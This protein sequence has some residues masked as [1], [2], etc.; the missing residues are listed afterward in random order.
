MKKIIIFILLLNTNY[1]FSQNLAINDYS[2]SNHQVICSA[3]NSDG[4]YLTTGGFDKKIVVWNTSNYSIVKEISGLDDIPLDII[5]SNDD[6][7]IISAGKDNKIT[8]WDFQTG[9]KIST[10]EGHSDDVT[11]ISICQNNNYIVSGSKDK[12]II[13]W[14]LKTYGR[15]YTLT[16]HTAEVNSVCFSNKGDK[17]IS[18]SADR[19]VKI[20]DTKKGHLLKSINAHDGWVRKV[21]Y[22]P[23]DKHFASCGNDGVINIW[24][25]DNNSLY[26]RISS[27]KK[28]VQ[29]ISYSPDGN[30]I[31]SGGHDNF[32][33]L[34]KI[35]NN[36]TIFK[37]KKNSNYVLTTNFNPNGKELFYG[38]L[39]SPKFKIL[40]IGSLN[41][42]KYQNID[43]TPPLITITSPN[44]SRGFKPVLQN[45]QLTII[46]VA[47]DPSGISKVLI[48]GETANIDTQGNFSKTVLLQIGDNSF[49]VSATD[50]N[51]NTQTETFVIEYSQDVVTNNQNN[52]SGSI[53]MGKYYALI[54]GNNNYNDPSITSLDEPINDATKLYNVL[55]TEYTFEPQNVM[56]L[57]NATYLQTIDAFDALSNKLTEND[58]LLVF[59]A[60]HGWW[61][62]DKELGYWLPTDAKQ[63]STGYWIRN[64]TISD[65]MGS[66]NSKHTLLIADACF[67]GSIFKTR[68]AFDDAGQGI[69]SLYELPSRTAMTSG[70]LKEVP[71]KSVFLEYLVKRLDNNTE[72][73]LSADQLFVSFRIA[74]MNN[75]QTEPQFGT[76][77]NAGDEGGEFIFI[78]KDK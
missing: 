77:Q 64:S 27:H 21:V 2:V 70:N 25:S 11:S 67:S 41:I 37:S 40:D 34:T 4:N 60:G 19:T 53:Q 54:I 74:V 55:T 68:A 5:F 57:K 7:Y 48:N 38:I 17:I 75:S 1:A 51:Q 29:T 6:K 39:L 9:N 23:D 65:Y 36:E 26:K 28:W 50:N 10:L 73:Y 52:N 44:I 45:N 71:D 30:Y 32:L 24:N 16:G 76:I 66:I 20:W 13:V 33:I 63:N 18:G 14:D 31:A 35:S 12:S 59:Y 8:V 22:S 78:R 62:E 69:N 58:N 15:V 61:D 56:F 43:N 72:K 42:Q 46:G 49:T 47:N 3:Y